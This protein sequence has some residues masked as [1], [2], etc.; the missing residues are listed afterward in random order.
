VLPAGALVAA[1]QLLLRHL[2]AWRHAI[3]IPIPQ[4][5]RRE[6]A[7]SLRTTCHRPATVCAGLGVLT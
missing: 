7:A 1:G 5:V 3:V 2:P 6:A 4:V